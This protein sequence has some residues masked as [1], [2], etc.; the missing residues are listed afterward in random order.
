[1]SLEACGISID[2][3]LCC[4]FWHS[5]LFKSDENYSRSLVTFFRSACN[6]KFYEHRDTRPNKELG[7]PLHT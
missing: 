5:S 6:N 4:V 3:H 1:M 7:E 2:R